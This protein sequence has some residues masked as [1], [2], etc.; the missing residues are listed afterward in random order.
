VRGK[1]I[2]VSIIMEPEVLARL[3]EVVGLRHSQGEHQRQVN[4]S[5][6]VAE[7]LRERWAR[8][9]SDPTLPALDNTP[10]Y[11]EEASA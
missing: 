3:R 2:T 7:A 4:L 10:H 11:E 1:R 9:D 8:M 5:S 6:L